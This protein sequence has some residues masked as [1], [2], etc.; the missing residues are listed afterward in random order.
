M[1]FSHVCF[2]WKIGVC[3][4]TVVRGLLY[5]S[6]WKKALLQEKRIRYLSKTYCT[7]FDLIFRQDF[8]ISV[9]DSEFTKFYHSEKSLK[10]V[11]NTLF[12]EISR[13]VTC[14]NWHIFCR[15]YFWDKQHADISQLI[16]MIGWLMA[17][18]CYQKTRFH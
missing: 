14:Q 10:A 18:H 7:T 3:Q 9:S 8:S 1:L 12:T 5:P 6:L 15:P 13:L 4:Q 16:L 17:V 11:D 2:D